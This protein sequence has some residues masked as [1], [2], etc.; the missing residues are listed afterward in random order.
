MPEA[1]RVDSTLGPPVLRP[2]VSKSWNDPAPAVGP[3]RNSPPDGPLNPSRTERKLPLI[4]EPQLSAN[5]HEYLELGAMVLDILDLLDDISGRYD[6]IRAAL[7]RHKQYIVETWK[8]LR[9]HRANFRTECRLLFSY[10][11]D[12]AAARKRL[13]KKQPSND[14][15]IALGK[16]ASERFPSSIKEFKDRLSSMERDI[17]NFLQ[18]IIG[19]SSRLV[20]ALSFLTLPL[21]SV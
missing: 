19:V 1:Q 14:D 7:H 10:L 6:E 11:L 18:A 9:A 2:A 13:D 20:S 17:G 15:L 8:D 12:P 5:G 21:K 3:I 16:T 4:S